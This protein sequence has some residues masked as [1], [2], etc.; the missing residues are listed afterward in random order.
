MERR[1]YVKAVGTTFLLTSLYPLSGAALG[2][3][4]SGIFP[5]HD[6]KDEY[7]GLPEEFYDNFSSEKELDRLYGDVSLDEDT[8]VLVDVI[9]VGERSLNESIKEEVERVHE[10]NGVNLDV[11]ERQDSFP[12]E[13]F[14]RRY[15]T[16]AG[17]I[18]GS[19]RGY[20]GFV[21]N[22]VS[23][24]MQEAAIQV[25]LAPGKKGDM[26]GW[27]EYEGEYRGG[28]ALGSQ[29]VLGSKEAFKQKYGSDYREGMALALTHEIGHSYG[30]G[31]SE[32]SDD[33]MH[34]DVNLGAGP[35]YEENEWEKIR[36]QLS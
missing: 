14:R 20:D 7:E 18:L 8:D 4:N 16:D 2:S 3:M 31:H 35:G 25:I 27:L 36:E 22:E 5:A 6:I 24:G 23:E 12:K 10:R 32:D 28:F 26:E 19:S 13:E 30:L 21:E 34:P 9:P 33:L 11:Y 17:K 15:G 1:D 29:T